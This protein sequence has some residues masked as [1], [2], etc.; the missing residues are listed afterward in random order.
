ME[1]YVGWL[2]AILVLIALI[3]FMIVSPGFRYLII[4][5]VVLG[6]IAIYGWIKYEEKESE[7]RQRTAA[8]QERAA[9]SA[10]SRTDITLDDVQLKKESSWWVLKGERHQQFQIPPRLPWIHSSDRGLPATKRVHHHRSG[11]RAG[12]RFRAAGQMRA[13]SSYSIDFK[14]MPA[15]SSPRWRYEIT[16]IRA[17]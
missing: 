3:F 15:A 6:G 7:R 10:L 4:G 14:G 13:F 1:G 5:I 2:I 17:D 11:E 8:A 9:Q 12:N 16:E